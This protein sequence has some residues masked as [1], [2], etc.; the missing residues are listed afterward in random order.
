MS[1]KLISVLLFMVVSVNCC[2]EILIRNVPRFDLTTVNQSGLTEIQAQALL[3]FSLKNEK[4]NVELSGFF[5]DGSLK[6]KKGNLYHPG[7]FS[8]GVGYDSPSAGATDVWGLF[9]VSP[10]TGDIWEE[11]SCRRISFPALQKIQKGIMKKPELRLPVKW[12]SAGGW[13]V[14]MS[15]TCHRIACRDRA[16]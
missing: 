14:R 2:A 11:D 12:F 1:C 3:V 9:S 13:V 15:S 5:L 16:G 4:Y 7:Y 6:D 8:F 10:V